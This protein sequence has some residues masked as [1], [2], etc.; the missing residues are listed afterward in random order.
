MGTTVAFSAREAAP[1][2]MTARTTIAK[3]TRI[4]RVVNEDISTS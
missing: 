3:T 2:K 4:T 1:L